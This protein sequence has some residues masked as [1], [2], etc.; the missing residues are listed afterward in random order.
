MDL[1]RRVVEAYLNGEGTYIEVAQRFAIG[2]ASVS[3]W[4]TRQRRTGDVAPRGHAGGQEH[5]IPDDELPLLVELVQSMP[6]A[7]AQELSD[8]WAKRYGVVLSRSAMQ[9]TLK[10]ADLRW[11]KNDSGRAKASNRTTSRIGKRSSRR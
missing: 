4:L 10:R 11:K 7:T 8:E 6:D 9:R 1:R 3:R 2:P 5:L